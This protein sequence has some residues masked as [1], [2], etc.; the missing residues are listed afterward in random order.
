MRL[1]ELRRG[2]RARGLRLLAEHSCAHGGGG[3]RGAGGGDRPVGAI[4]AS[5]ATFLGRPRAALGRGTVASSNH[6]TAIRSPDRRRRRGD[7]CLFGRLR[8][9]LLDLGMAFGDSSLPHPRPHSPAAS[10]AGLESWSRGFAQP[11]RQT[12]GAAAGA[13]CRAERNPHLRVASVFP[14]TG[15]RCPLLR[16][17]PK[18]LYKGQLIGTRLVSKKATPRWSLPF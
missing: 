18:P 9:E 5:L 4:A 17:K 8:T 12:M 7:R 6:T 1:A 15:Y 14:S 10:W 3:P 2:C 13:H 16:L 11:P